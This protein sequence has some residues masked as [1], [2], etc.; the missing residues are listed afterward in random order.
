MTEGVQVIDSVY[1]AECITT[2]SQ[3]S[4][5]I[6]S[7]A[8]SDLSRAQQLSQLELLALEAACPV[9]DP[10]TFRRCLGQFTTGVAIVAACSEQTPVAMTI[11]SFSALS[12]NPPLILWSLRSESAKLDIFRNAKGFSVNVLSSEQRGVS[13]RFAKSGFPDM[14]DDEWVIEQAANPFLRGAIA[15]F[16]CLTERVEQVGDH[17]IF[18]GRVS[19]CKRFSGEPLIFKQGRYAAHAA[20][21]VL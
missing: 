18:I 1:E 7:N 10:A 14:T 6:T 13:D 9:E 16:D 19:H 12:L 2:D 4:E 15:H 11:N 17:F 21:E 3:G 8:A 20:S 5:G